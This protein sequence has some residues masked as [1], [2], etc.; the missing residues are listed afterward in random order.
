RLHYPR[1]KLV[2]HLRLLQLAQSRSI[3]RGDID[4]KVAR[5]RS[6]GLDQA[7]IVSDAVGA[8][9]VR[10]NINA[11]DATFVCA[12]GKT[13]QHGGGALAVEA[14]P[15]DHALVAV[16]PK[17]ARTQVAS[18]RQRRDG[19]NLDKTKTKLEQRVG[20]LGMLVEARCHAH[21][22]GEIEPEGT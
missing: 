7:H 20:Y 2:E 8:F 6:K 9:P 5:H 3:G 12:R 4:G 11:D 1:Q 17:D 13:A 22:I 15:I 21:R 18:L 19:S 14:Q 16:E 10:A